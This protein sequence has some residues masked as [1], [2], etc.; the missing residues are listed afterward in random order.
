MT[1]E[2]KARILA[3]MADNGYITDDLLVNARVRFPAPGKDK[4]NKAAYA[5]TGD[6][7]VTY[8]DYVTGREY[9]VR[10]VAGIEEGHTR[11]DE[12]RERERKAKNLRQRRTMHKAEWMLEQS[13][14]A[15][16]DHPYLRKKQLAPHE[17]RQFQESLLVPLYDVYD[18][19]LWN[20]ERIYHDG[21]KFVLRNG[22]VNGLGFVVGAI[23]SRVYLAE[24]W[25]TC[26]TIHAVTGTAVVGARNSGNLAHVGRALR[27]RFPD[28][29]I[30]IASDNDYGVRGNPGL[31]A[32]LNLG[33]ELK[34]P[35]RQCPQLEGV[36]DFNDLFIKKGAAVVAAHLRGDRQ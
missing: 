22:R 25:A 32:A 2:Q 4:Q 31:N 14:P 3:I 13:K 23:G 29:E 20:V 12:V 6:E 28:L 7:V 15:N 11:D 9:Q 1:P 10:Y 36:S 27:D 19:K 18:D 34:L 26:A 17:L 16:P 30:I 5:F 33:F 8:G 21:S 24:G 35:V